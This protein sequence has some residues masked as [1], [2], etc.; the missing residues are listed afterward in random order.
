MVHMEP[1]RAAKRLWHVARVVLYMLRKRLS[2]GKFM[3]DLHLLIERG[4]IAG[5]ALSNL[6]TF[7]H[8][9][10]HDPRGD[11][12]FMFSGFSCRS[13]D[14]N[15]SFY[16]PREVEFSCSNTPAYPSF[17]A[18]KRK[19]RRRRYHD[20]DYDYDAAKVFEILN[21]ELSDAESDVTSP[22]PAPVIWNFGKSPAVVRQL[23]ITDS[24]FPV[25]DAEEDV[26]FHID[27]KAEEF[28]RRF[29][30]Q[31]RLQ[32]RTPMTPEFQ[33]YRRQPLMGRA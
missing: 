22:S 12:S 17:R 16:S 14:P 33:R 8:H 13:T 6:M 28:I 5:K 25:R 3:M 29:Y 11:G 24:P 7:H 2:K 27:E 18:A 19:S 9:D 1:S 21:S 30:E 10:R 15:L 26:D 20:D 31:L 23:R 32:Q 4:K